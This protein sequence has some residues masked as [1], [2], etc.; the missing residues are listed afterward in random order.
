MIKERELTPLSFPSV[1]STQLLLNMNKEAI[2]Y[3]VAIK[4]ARPMGTWKAN[5]STEGNQILVVSVI[6]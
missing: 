1:L 5:W 6:Y 2:H 3:F 4:W